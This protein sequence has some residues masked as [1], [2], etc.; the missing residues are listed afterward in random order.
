MLTFVYAYYENPGMLVEHLR[1]WNRYPPNTFKFIVVDDG[2]QRTPALSVIGTGPINPGLRLF[3]IAQNIPWN[4]DGARNLGMFQCETEWAWISDMD[5]FV[6]VNEAVKMERFAAIEALPGEYYMPMRRS[7]ADGS[8]LHP[9][10]NCYLFRR[11]DFW[12]MG[13]Y[14]EDFAGCYGSD[15]NFRKCARAMLRES[16]TVAFT[17]VSFGRSEIPDASTVDFGRKDSPY[18]RPNFPHLEAKRRAPPYM[19]RNHMRFDWAE[20]RLR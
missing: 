20:V 17:T 12:K 9:H 5:Q 13:G 11:D 4:Q 7:A 16:Q 19:A 3:R 2:S 15:G 1:E 14:D 10:P 8:A 18:W 6:P